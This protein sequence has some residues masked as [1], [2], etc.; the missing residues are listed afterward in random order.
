MIQRRPVLVASLLG[1]ALASGFAGAPSA[2]GSETTGGAPVLIETSVMPDLAATRKRFQAGPFSAIWQLPAMAPARAKFD[3]FLATLKSE[4]GIDGAAIL[5][6]ATAYR[7]QAFAA[8]GTMGFRLGLRLPAT[9]DAQ[10]AAMTAKQPADA[11]GAITKDGF[12][13]THGAGWLMGAKGVPASAAEIS[14]P[15]APTGCDGFTRVDITAIWRALELPEASA[16]VD[17]LHLSTIDYACVFTPG[18]SSE[19]LDM[20]RFHLPLQ[21]V[22]AAAL[23]CLPED[24]ILVAAAG[25]DG[26]K[27]SA[28]IATCATASPTLDT[29][30]HSA[31]QALGA[32]ALPPI[33]ALL[34]SISGTAYLAITRGSPFPG[35]T[36]AVPASAEIDR[37]LDGLAGS[38]STDQPLDLAAARTTAQ[39]IPLPNGAPVM[40]QIRRTATHW[41]LSSDA[42]VM[43]ALEAAPDPAA[44]S[45][46]DLVAKATVLAAGTR[47][48]A[49]FYEDNRALAELLVNTGGLAMGALGAKAKKDPEAKQQL[50]MLRMVM[51]ALSAAAPKLPNSLMAVLDRAD[52]THVMMEN[53]AVPA[54]ASAI[55]AGMA[56]P[57]IA[58][59]RAAAR[60][61]SSGNNERQIILGALVFANE[62]DGKWPADL[63]VVRKESQLPAALFTSPSDPTVADPYCYVRPVPEAEAMQPVLV[64]DPACNKGKGS[65]VTFGDGHVEYLKGTL[66][67]AEAKRLAALPK[68]KADGIEAKDWAEIREPASAP[69]AK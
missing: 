55:G 21:P 32:M 63:A 13:W 30:I 17:A 56:L 41:V 29:G 61:A 33:A 39:V 43:M 11:T 46:L 45:L 49:V 65:M 27:L 37:A 59:T 8:S 12:A 36:I 28:M 3:A 4:R 6:D 64:E 44:K 62:N 60:R 53:G 69:D 47:P 24:A 42:A 35:V 14:A 5:A 67:W 38:M 22:D 2:S 25:I 15:S 40:L 7:E 50:E 20:P 34:G 48:N 19:S 54:W 23:S 66:A 52:G 9:L 18:G 1:L 10:W 31:D 58:M 68:A 57:A 51:T 16:A 26:H